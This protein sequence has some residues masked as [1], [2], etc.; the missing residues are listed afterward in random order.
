MSHGH[1]PLLLALAL[2]LASPAAARERGLSQA[3]C[4]KAAGELA[5]AVAARGAKGW[6]EGVGT[7]PTVAIAA[8]R[9]CEATAVDPAGLDRALRTALGRDR[10]LQ[11]AK[12]SEAASGDDGLRDDDD[13][14]AIDAATLVVTTSVYTLVND[15]GPALGVSMALFDIAAQA[16]LARATT[17][18]PRAGRARA[19]RVTGPA[20]ATMATAFA[21]KVAQAARRGWPA[22]YGDAPVVAIERIRNDS[23]DAELEPAAI[24]AAVRDALHA[25][26]KVVLAPSAE[27]L[28]AINAEADVAASTRTGPDLMGKAAPLRAVIDVELTAVGGKVE[29]TLRLRAIEGGQE[30]VT[31][32]S[33]LRGR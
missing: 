15:E 14:K 6:P 12:A 29:A 7:R 11:V 9:G 33:A 10:R 32:T 17:T 26:G 18:F 13:S 4:A 8:A 2:A 31:S 25:G 27:D 22:G 23:G 21:D 24:D 20:L 3:D 30:L 19:G 28:E 16:T 5:R 1:A